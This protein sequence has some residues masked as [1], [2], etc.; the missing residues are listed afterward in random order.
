LGDKNLKNKAFDLLKTY[1]NE[2]INS[3]NWIYSNR[4]TENIIEKDRLI[5]I[6]AKNN[7]KDTLIGTV[8]SILC[9][10]RIFNEESIVVSMA[11]TPDNRIKISLRSINNKTDLSKLICEVCSKLN[12]IGG[13]HPNAAGGLISIEKENE[14]IKEIL[15]KF[16]FEVVPNNK[17][18][19]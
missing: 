11:H 13:G 8:N 1:K 15:S 14:F 9:K 5:I 4:G 7:I 10:S 2:I 18:N 6:N 19:I 3:M 12:G 16:D 17:P